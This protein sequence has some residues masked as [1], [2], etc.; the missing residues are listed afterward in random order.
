MKRIALAGLVIFLAAFIVTCDEG[1]PGEVEYTNVVYSED[2]MSITVY[3]DGATVPVT[4]SQ[5]AITR[6][7]AKMAY[8]FIEVIFIHDTYL[9][10]TSWELGQSAGISGVPRE[11]DYVWGSGKANDV[12]LMFVGRKDGKTLLGIGRIEEVDHSATKSGGYVPATGYPVAPLSFIESTSQSVT[13]FI[14]AIKT[15]LKASNDDAYP[16]S[17]DKITDISFKPGTGTPA[18]DPAKVMRSTP[19]NG[20][21]KGS[22]AYPMYTLEEP[23]GTVYDADYEFFGAADTYSEEII[24]AGDSL[25]GDSVIVETRFPRFMDGGRY[26]QPQQNIDTMSTVK[27]AGSYPTV[28]ALPLVETFDPVIPLKITPKMYG[29]FSFFLEIPCYMISNDDTT[30]SGSDAIIWKI[31][32][33]LGSELYSLD[34]GLSSGGCVLMGVGVSSLDW[35][36]IEWAWVNN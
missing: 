16:T 21:G 30:N 19:N 2:G 12:A 23:D 3:L 32:T 17:Y 13:F 36:E 8:D 1:L 14:E 26:L 7:L 29:I 25:A 27:V 28:P 18:F 24:L 10:R 5:R 4:K 34:D 35:L 22:L 9:A 31:R 11:V 33:G 6:N 20:S 15:G